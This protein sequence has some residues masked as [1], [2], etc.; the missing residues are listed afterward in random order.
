[1]MDFYRAGD[2]ERAG[3]RLVLQP[4][5][6]HYSNYDDSYYGFNK[7]HLLSEKALR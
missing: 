7:D 4:N 2:L 5:Y 1:M 6:W 3:Q